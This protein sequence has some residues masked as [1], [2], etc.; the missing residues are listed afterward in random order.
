MD[1]LVTRPSHGYHLVAPLGRHLWVGCWGGLMTEPSVC[2][3]AVGSTALYTNC[4]TLTVGTGSLRPGPV[5][6][7]TKHMLLTVVLCVRRGVLC[8]MFAG[9][10]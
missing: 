8:S 4:T 5:L 1:C 3:I 6:M 9:S 10:L 2:V 7:V